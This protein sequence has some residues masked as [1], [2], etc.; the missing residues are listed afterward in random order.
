MCAHNRHS[1]RPADLLKR[2]NNAKTNFLRGKKEGEKVREDFPAVP[3]HRQREILHQLRMKVFKKRIEHYGRFMLISAALDIKRGR[4]SKKKTAGRENI[5]RW[6]KQIRKN[7]G[8]KERIAIR[9]LFYP[10]YHRYSEPQRR[11]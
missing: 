5:I 11:F 7:I 4:I 10:V 2:K 8:N 3:P 6:R 1:H 9:C